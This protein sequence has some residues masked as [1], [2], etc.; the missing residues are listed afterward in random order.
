MFALCREHSGEGREHRGGGREHRGEGR[1][2]MPLL[3][4]KQFCAPHKQL[5]CLRKLTLLCTFWIPHFFWA[6]L[7]VTALALALAL[8]LPHLTVNMLRFSPQVVFFWPQNVK[9]EAFCHD[10]GYLSLSCRSFSGSPLSA[11][12]IGGRGVSA[13][14]HCT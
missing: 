11:P 6:F 4:F 3:L 13:E 2:R 5:L 14:G 10:P 1:T 7:T 12:P 8:G 9:A